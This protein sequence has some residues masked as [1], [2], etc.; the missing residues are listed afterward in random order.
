MWQ[1]ILFFA[2]IAIVSLGL[3]GLTI[4]YWSDYYKAVGIRD[5][6]NQ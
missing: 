3:I 1:D 4:Y 2:W 5:D 6:E